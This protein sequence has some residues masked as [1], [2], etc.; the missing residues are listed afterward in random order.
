M[1]N[2]RLF[3]SKLSLMYMTVFIGLL[4]LGL[5]FLDGFLFWQWAVIRKGGECLT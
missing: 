4:L 1:K 3:F 5:V 2:D